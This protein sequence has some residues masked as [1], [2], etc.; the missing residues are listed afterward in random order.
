[1]FPGSQAELQKHNIDGILIF[2]DARMQQW[3]RYLFKKKAMNLLKTKKA[4]LKLIMSPIIEHH[5]V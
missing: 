4:E 5:H 2:P 1:M 3:I